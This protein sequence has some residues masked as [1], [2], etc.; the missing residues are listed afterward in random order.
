MQQRKRVKLKLRDSCDGCSD[1]KIKCNKDKPVCSRCNVKGLTCCYGPSHRSGRRSTTASKASERPQKSPTSGP[2]PALAQVAAPASQ[3]AGTSNEIDTAAALNAASNTDFHFSIDAFD[4]P[5]IALGGAAFG[6]TPFST[7]PEP[8]K[9][10][11]STPEYDV[12]ALMSSN[13]DSPNDNNRKSDRENSSSSSISND[14]LTYDNRNDS[15]SGMDGMTYDPQWFSNLGLTFPNNFASG[16]AMPPSSSYA[17]Q[18]TLPDISTPSSLQS[19]IFNHQS[20]PLPNTNAIF[21]TPPPETSCTCLTQAL[22][23]LAALHD[24]NN[25][26]SSTSSTPSV[27]GT[28]TPPYADN[29]NNKSI[30]LRNLVGGGTGV[31]NVTTT[32]HES[33]NLNTTSLQQATKILSC[34]CSTHNQQLIFFVAFIV[35]KTMDRYTAAVH[36]ADT[37]DRDSGGGV[38]SEFPLSYKD[39]LESSGGGCKGNSRTRAQL[40][41]G[42]LHRVVRIVDALSKRMREGQGRRSNSSSES[43]SQSG[44]GKGSEVGDGGL[45]G[46]P[47]GHQISASCFAQLE[48]DLR[49]HLKAV[50]NDTMSILRRE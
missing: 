17:P 39:S 48:N 12:A 11:L 6:T 27:I 37:L 45:Q 8:L 10:D 1:A 29:D 46:G 13:P 25:A 34:E 41:L 44:G 30:S 38:G 28:M 9:L 50:T 35:L 40:V 43:S 18:M 19:S 23:L 3:P 21:C 31:K 26:S 42:E 22:S 24:N 16:L 47:G 32:I 49:K 20:F 15:I 33:L 14:S 5:D 4:F 36:G 7:F 2:V